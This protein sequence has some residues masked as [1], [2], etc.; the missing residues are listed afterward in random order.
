MINQNEKNEIELNADKNEEPIFYNTNDVARILGCSE[1]TAR[2][3]MNRRDFPLIKVGKNFRVYKVAFE[4]W[5][6]ERRIWTFAPLNKCF[7][8]LERVS[9]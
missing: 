5:A 9:I 2:E 6:L 3:V 4:N 7:T 8:V 1:P